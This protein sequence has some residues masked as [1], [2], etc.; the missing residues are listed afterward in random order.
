MGILEGQNR[1]NM[2]FDNLTIK[3]LPKTFLFC[4]DL[5]CGKHTLA[6]AVA[7]KLNLKLQDITENFSKDLIIDLS[8]TNIPTLYLV[9]LSVLKKDDQN[10]LLKWTEEP[11][12]ATFICL[13]SDSYHRVL[14][15]ILNRC[16]KYEF[17]QYSQDILK[18]YI[19][20]EISPENSF[21]ALKVFSTIGQIKMFRSQNLVGLK[22]LCD[23]L[24]TLMEKANLQNALSVSNRFNYSD[25]YDKYDVELFFR[26]LAQSGVELSIQD[27]DKYLKY[28][29]IIN[30]YW[31]Q[32]SNNPKL[33]K[34]YIIDGLLVSLWKE[35][36]GL[37]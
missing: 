16:I 13:L 23:G 18:R 15:T 19:D 6:K 9:D 3:N 36:R 25:E 1:L 8:Y 30:K 31:S 5:G 26:M 33:N 14:P 24:I 11:N 32:L 27:T 7:D 4:G 29:K 10:I 20:S 35:S 34:Q 17:E 21:L 12:D 28:Y 2:W 37:L 22:K